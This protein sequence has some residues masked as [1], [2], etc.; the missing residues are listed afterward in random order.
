VT[1]DQEEAI[2]MSDRVVVMNHGRIEQVGAPR[3]LYYRP[4]TEFVAGFFG[5]NNIIEGRALAGGEI[6]TPIGRFRLGTEWD[7]QSGERLR[8][9]IRPEHLS[10]ARGNGAAE[11]FNA[12]VFDVDFVGALTHIRLRVSEGPALKLKVPT[13]QLGEDIRPG[14]TVDVHWAAESMCVLRPVS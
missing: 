2:T 10:L 8:L 9:A 14:S 12:Q 6:D 4:A 3:E 1:H 5:D 13:P 11:T 7:L